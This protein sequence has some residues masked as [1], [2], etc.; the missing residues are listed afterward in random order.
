[1]PEEMPASKVAALCE[2]EVADPNVERVVRQLNAICK[3]A[4]LDFALA[5]GKVVV[6]Q[7]YSGDLELWRSRSPKKHVSLRKL[8]RHPLLPMSAGALYRSVSMYELCK[9][10][11]ITSWK[12]ISTSHMRLVL[13]LAADEQERLLREAEDNAWSVRRLDKEVAAIM[14]GR[15]TSDEKGGGRKRKSRLRGTLLRVETC[16]AAVDQALADGDDS[17]SDRSPE[18]TRAAIDM[19]RRAARKCEVLQNKLATGSFDADSEV[20]V[21][22]FDASAV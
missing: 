21:G 22:S 11:N 13:P 2:G 3:A 1:M 14:I 8:S 10:L 6:E 18:S 4:T 16:L 9:R 7:F 17:V 5:V 20:A 12:S 15:P 19:L